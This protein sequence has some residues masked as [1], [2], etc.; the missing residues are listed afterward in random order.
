[1][2]HLV[3]VSVFLWAAA[4]LG[5]NFDMGDIVVVPDPRGEINGLI[6]E[7]G[8]SI[9]PSMQEQFCRA[10]YNQMRASAHPDVYDGVITF[11]AAN[12]INDL[13]NVW[14]GSPVRSAGKNIGRDTVNFQ[15]SAYNS[16]RLSQCVF[17]GTLGKT[18]PI[19]NEPLPADPDK[20]WSPSLGV[21]IPIPSETGIEMMGHEFG[22]HWLLGIEFDLADGKGKRHFIR[23]TSTSGGGEGGG[24]S[25]TPNQHYSL[26]ADSRSVMYGSCITPKGGNLYQLGGCPRKYSHIDQYL[27]GLRG[28]DEVTPMMVLE[29]PASPNE[30]VDSIPYAT[31]SSGKEVSGTPYMVTG[32]SIVRAMGARDPAYPTA[33]NCWRVAFIVVLAPGETTLSPAM[34]QKVER[35]RQRW[36][37]WFSFATDGRGTMDSRALGDG[38]IF[39]YNPDGGTYVFDAG[40]PV[41]DAGPVEE[42]DA[43]VVLPEDPI[44]AGGGTTGPGDAGLCVGVNC[45][46]GQIRPGCGC[47]S[48]SGLEV[49]A[50]LSLLAAVLRRRFARG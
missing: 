32:E 42:S 35:Y 10:A 5:Q 9:Y 3:S 28:A 8:G 21:P 38:C 48:A 14:Q 33:K 19:P 16:S 6:T 44:D 41:V 47:G 43:G 15:T 50:G 25:N 2:R 30:G 20:P 34:Y 13:A 46:I 49:F 12:G 4:A 22:H 7:L 45:D 24:G 23:A 31:G 40:Q 36:S 11:T 27:M 26:L 1:M 37:G 17:M 39:G 18:G 29:D